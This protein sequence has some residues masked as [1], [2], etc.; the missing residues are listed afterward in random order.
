LAELIGIILNG[1]LRLST[2][3]IERIHL[4]EVSFVAQLPDLG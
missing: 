2:A 1:G 3:G 4:A